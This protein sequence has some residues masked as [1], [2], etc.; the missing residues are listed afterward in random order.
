MPTYGQRYDLIKLRMLQ[1]LAQPQVVEFGITGTQALYRSERG[2]KP[3]VDKERLLEKLIED[4]LVERR[5]DPH[6]R[7]AKPYFITQLGKD[8]LVNNP[9]GENLSRLD[10]EPTWATGLTHARLR[11]AL[12]EVL[13]NLPEFAKAPEGRVGHVVDKIARNIEIAASDI[14][15]TPPTTRRSR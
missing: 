11:H 5:A 12:A 8:Y 1:T 10:V 6:Q 14:G 7:M 3:P 2:Y 9:E 15:D 13:G 4:G